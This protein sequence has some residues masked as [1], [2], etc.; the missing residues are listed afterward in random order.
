[1]NETNKTNP[2]ALALEKAIQYTNELDVKTSKIREAKTNAQFNKI[3]ENEIRQQTMSTISLYGKPDEYY[4]NLKQDNTEYLRNAKTSPVFLTEDFNDVVPFFE[5]NLIVIGAKSGEGK[6]TI[7]ANIAYSLVTQA[8]HCLM[9]TNEEVDTDVFN[10]VTCLMKKWPY[11]NHKSFTEEQIETFNQNYKVLGNRLS[12]INDMSNGSGGTTTTI[13]GLKSILDKVIDSPVKPACII[14]DYFQNICEDIESIGESEY[15][16]LKRVAGLLDRYRKYVGCPIV[17]LVQ[18]KAESEEK[19]DFKFR[20]E[21]CKE[22]YTKST[23]AL[24][25]RADRENKTTIFTVRKARFTDSLG[26]DITVGFEKG[27]Y[28]RYDQNYKSKILMDKDS[29]KHNEILSNAF[30]KDKKY[31]KTST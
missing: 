13:Q 31:E 17:V 12:V 29:K 10:R 5:K 9:I 19:S 26:K 24:E 1:M 22:I 6:S 21:H 18:L 20:I 3:V 11:N 14:V 4:D 15:S 27:R 23:C 8:A 2:L 7:A 25:V 30:S 28:V 16:V